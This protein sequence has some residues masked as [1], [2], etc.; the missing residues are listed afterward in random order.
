MNTEDKNISQSEL[1]KKEQLPTV[2]I[3]KGVHIIVM[4]G[5]QRT[6]KFS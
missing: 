4:L 6:K 2:I 3:I 1:L 5:K